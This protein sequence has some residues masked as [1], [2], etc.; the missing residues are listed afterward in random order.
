M[1]GFLSGLLH[2]KDALLVAEHDLGLHA[3]GVS[4]VAASRRWVA[5][6][7]SEGTEIRIWDV[8]NAQ[9][10]GTLKGHLKR[11]EALAISTNENQI[12]SGSEDGEVRIWDTTGLKE[13]ARWQR[14]GPVSALA[15]T[16]DGKSLAI[17]GSETTVSCVEISS[18]KEEQTFHLDSKSLKQILEKPPEKFSE[19][20]ISPDQTRWAAIGGGLVVV[21]DVQKGGAG[22]VHMT[23][24]YSYHSLR[25]SSSGEHLLIAGGTFEVEIEFTAGGSTNAHFKNMGGV[26]VLL[27]VLSGKLHSVSKA[28]TVFQNAAFSPEGEKVVILAAAPPWKD[29]VRQWLCIHSTK[30][31]LSG[32]LRK[33][34]DELELGQGPLFMSS[35][36]DPA[37]SLVVFEKAKHVHLSQLKV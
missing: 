18:G 10:L 31:I 11:V 20:A 9:S 36:F 22:K 19:V 28:E 4:E 37:S 3:G 25:F 8:L 5:S 21:W 7:P 30:E 26:I 32:T 24:P 27:D 35:A 15:F 29:G 14:S 16:A 33:P 23:P 13:L 12:A 34:E 2:S 17:A 1:P 6:A